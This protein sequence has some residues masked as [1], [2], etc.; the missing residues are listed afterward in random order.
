MGVSNRNFNLV[1]YYVSS[2]FDKPKVGEMILFGFVPYALV[3]SECSVMIFMSLIVM[4][5]DGG[6]PSFCEIRLRCIIASRRS[7]S[8]AAYRE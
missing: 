2:F 3:I 7:F 4:I 1:I 8:T 6:K 5:N